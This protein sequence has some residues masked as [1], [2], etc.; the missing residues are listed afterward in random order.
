[1][2]FATVYKYVF[3]SHKTCSDVQ[4]KSTLQGECG[5]VNLNCKSNHKV[6]LHCTH[7]DSPLMISFDIFQTGNISS[8]MQIV[9][10]YTTTG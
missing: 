9:R 1:L 3:D 6:E 8:F 4:S 2:I 10:W 7:N 5:R